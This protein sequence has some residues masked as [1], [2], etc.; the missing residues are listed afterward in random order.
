M[1]FPLTVFSILLIPGIGTPGV[2]T[3]P[4]CN[5]QWLKDH[6]PNESDNPRVLTF[7]YSVP[8]NDSY[9][10]ETLLMQGYDLLHALW[11]LRSNTGSNE[12]NNLSDH[13]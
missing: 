9:T 7:E 1:K 4:F 6:Y 3:W 11:D 8:I 13:S 10:W 2:E 5:Q 12:V